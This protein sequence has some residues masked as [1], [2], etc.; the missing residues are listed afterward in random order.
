[1][2]IVYHNY[3][4]L[5][6]KISGF[7]VSIERLFQTNVFLLSIGIMRLGVYYNAW[8]KHLYEM[9]VLLL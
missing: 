1:M 2:K 3:T 9:L 7:Q 4:A 8:I 5:L 6:L